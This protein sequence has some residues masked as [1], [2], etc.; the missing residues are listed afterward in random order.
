MIF[1]FLLAIDRTCLLLK[2]PCNCWRTHH[3]WC[4]RGVTIQHNK[5]AI[6]SWKWQVNM[7]VIKTRVSHIWKSITLKEFFLAVT[8]PKFLSDSQI[9]IEMVGW[10]IFSQFAMW[11]RFSELGRDNNSITFKTK[12]WLSCWELTLTSLRR[13]PCLF[14]FC[15]Q[16]RGTLR[17]YQIM[18]Y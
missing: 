12:S 6:P 17:L 9:S 8:L 4:Y 3:I 1:A 15:S 16:D 11:V 14:I 2:Q 10:N 7:F 18:R 5:Y 13:I